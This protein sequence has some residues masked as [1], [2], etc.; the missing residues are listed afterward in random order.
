MLKKSRRYYLSKSIR[1]NIAIEHFD[2][3]FL[4][5]KIKVRSKI[6]A[7]GIDDKTFDPTDVGVHLKAQEFNNMITDPNT[8]LVDMRNHS[9]TE[10]G[11]FENADPRCGYLQRFIGKNEK[12]IES[13]KT[14]KNIVMYCTGG[15][16]CERPAHISNIRALELFQLE[17]VLSNIQRG[18]KQNLENK[19][20]GKN[21][22]LINNSGTH[23]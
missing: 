9:E 20:K 22:V 19:F 16:R 21:F 13:L 15:I 8:I 7:D 11:H 2:K 10:I 14:N 4:K 17:E 6:L 3:S 23:L 5:L 18:K 1:L 12:D